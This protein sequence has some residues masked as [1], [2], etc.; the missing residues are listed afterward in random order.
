MAKEI[1]KVGNLVEV[2]ETQEVILETFDLKSIQAAIA[3]KQQQITNYPQTTA[4][5]FQNLRDQ[6]SFLQAIL[7]LLR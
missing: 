1:R 6:E 7:A 2:Y 3:T 4:Q 5:H